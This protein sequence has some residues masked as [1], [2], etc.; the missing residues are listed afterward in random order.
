MD[1]TGSFGQYCFQ[2]MPFGIYIQR[3]RTLPEMTQMLSG[4]DGVLCVVDEV[5]VFE[6]KTKHDERLT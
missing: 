4:L 2:K 6:D 1:E 5:L 3:S